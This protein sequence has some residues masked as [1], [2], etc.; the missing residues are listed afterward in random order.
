M[1]EQQALFE[2]SPILSE[3]NEALLLPEKWRLIQP[4]V[5][6]PR[7]YPYRGELHTQGEIIRV[8]FDS[9][10]EAKEWACIRLEA[11]RMN[12]HIKIKLF[13]SNVQ[14]WQYP[15]RYDSQKRVTAK[16]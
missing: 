9:F 11:K 2:F 1:N 5:S 12:D 4:R 6:F 16:Q 15:P 14:V 3:V 7:E 8:S 10:V 13:R